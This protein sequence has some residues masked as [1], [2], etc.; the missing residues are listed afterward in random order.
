MR[1]DRQDVRPLDELDN[2]EVADHSPDVRGWDVMSS[3]GRRIGEVEELLVDTNAMKVR[4]LDV[5]LDKDVRGASDD[6][7]VLIPIGRARI[8]DND[9]RVVVDGVGAEQFRSMPGYSGRL[10]RNYEDTLRTHWSGSSRSISDS[11]TADLSASGRLST[12]RSGSDR[13]SAGAADAMRSGSTGERD[14][15]SDEHFDDSRFFGARRGTGEGLRPRTGRERNDREERL[16]LSEEQLAIGKRQQEAGEVHVGKHVET[17]HVRREVPLKREEAVIERRP[18]AEGDRMHA[19]ARIEDDEIHIP[20]HEEK[21]VV[22][23]R[24]VPTEELVVK[25]RTVEETE[26]VESDLRR[27]RADIEGEGNVRRTD[28]RRDR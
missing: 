6:R 11:G 2:F 5:E 21:A 20:L 23:K 17:E 26:T 4:Y 18:V 9:D 16:T 24:V 7:R 10:D 28:S 27:E 19:K 3:D 22:E 12:E 8:D 13:S 14:Y 15:Y 25:K 1:D